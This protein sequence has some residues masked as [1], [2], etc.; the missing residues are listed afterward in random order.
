MTV[1]ATSMLTAVAEPTDAGSATTATEATTPGTPAAEATGAKPATGTAAEATEGTAT[2]AEGKPEGDKQ[3][4]EGAPEKY[5][6]FTAPEGATLAPELVTEA[7]ALA[8]ELNLSQDK[9]QKVVELAAKQTAQT[10]KAGT[11]AY[12]SVRAAWGEATKADP[13]FGGDKLAESLATARASMEATTTPALR[14]LLAKTGLGDN[15]EVIRHFLKIAPAFAQDKH[16]PGG[17]APG[18]AKSA[19]KVLYPNAA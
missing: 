7:S 10:L 15:A 3:V 8:K 16:V 11:E 19:A 17:K 14:E 12:Q 6:D 13:E 4:V 18:A 2:E 9:A 1:E 5:A